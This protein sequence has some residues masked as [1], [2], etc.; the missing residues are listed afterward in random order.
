LIADRA[1]VSCE[2][3]L[4]D[5]TRFDALLDVRS[6]GEFADDH[7]PGAINAPVLH[8]AE[9]VEVGTLYRQVSPFDGA[10]PRRGSGRAQHRINR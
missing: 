7:L 1:V 8:D 3:V 10:P 6:E 9:R 2:Q 5:L 4:Q